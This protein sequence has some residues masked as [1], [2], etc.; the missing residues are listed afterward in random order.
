MRASGSIDVKGGYD[1]S[2]LFGSFD[3][4]DEGRAPLP[5]L[6]LLLLPFPLIGVFEDDEEPGDG[7]PVLLRDVI[8]A[9]ADGM[10]AVSSASAS[11]LPG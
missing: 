7:D 10:I 8:S 2:F 4:V 5:L 6:P 9:V 11:A 3:N 1:G